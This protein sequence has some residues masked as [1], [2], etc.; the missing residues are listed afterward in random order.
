[1]E[2]GQWVSRGLEVDAWT[3]GDQNCGVDRAQWVI[4]AGVD[5]WT[6]GVS[7]VMEKE[8]KRSVENSAC[9]YEHAK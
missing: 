6:V 1:M 9:T 7:M 4:R 8:L 5:A 3:V 2:R